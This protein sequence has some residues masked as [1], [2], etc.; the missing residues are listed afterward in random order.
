MFMNRF[1]TILAD[2][3]SAKSI[4]FGLRYKVFCEEAGFED[5]AGFPDRKERDVFDAEAA[6]FLVWD[7]F[8]RTWVGAMRLIDAARRDMPCEVICT[9]SLVQNACRR[10]RSMEFSRLCIPAEFRHMETGVTWGDWFP[11]GVSADRSSRVVFWQ[12]ENEILLRLLRA[13]FAWGM[14]YGLEDCY[15]L[16]TRALVRLLARLGIPLDNLG[17]PVEHRG[18]RIPHRYHVRDANNGIL[19]RTVGYRKLV[20]KSPAYTSFTKFIADQRALAGREAAS[21][22]LV[23][24]LAQ[25][26]LEHMRYGREVLG[27]APSRVA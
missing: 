15:F 27:E 11:Y 10:A 4:N 16:I 17:A 22:E 3:A 18:L 2:T 9:R 25:Q 8:A 23:P 19:S 26:C 7:H 6:H 1:E 13:S 21:G 20:D 5:A 24:A 12:T 14:K